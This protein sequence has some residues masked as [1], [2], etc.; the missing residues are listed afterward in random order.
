[1]RQSDGLSRLG[2]R[3]CGHQSGKMLASQADKQ[4]LRRVQASDHIENSGTQAHAVL[5]DGDVVPA[6]RRV[7]P[8]RHGLTAQ[9]LQRLFHM[10]EK[11]LGLAVVRNTCQVRPIQGVESEN[12]FPS[13]LLGDDSLARQ[14]QRVRELDLNQRVQEAVLSVAKVDG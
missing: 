6:S 13:D 11:I 7:H 9:T 4:S 8:S 1:M 3:I 12:A 2:M 10:K 5:S 14:H